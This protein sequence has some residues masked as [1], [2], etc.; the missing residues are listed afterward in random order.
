VP[1][2]CVQPLR[3]RQFALSKGLLAK[4]DRLDARLLAD[5]GQSIQP[6]LTPPTSALQKQIGELFTFSR[7]LIEQRTAVVN[8]LEHFHSAQARCLVQKVLRASRP[9]SNGSLKALIA[10]DAPTAQRIQRLC[11]IKGVGFQTALSLSCLLAE[12]GSI[13][14]QQLAALVGVAPFVRDSAPRCAKRSIRG[15]RAKLRSQLD[16]A[17]WL[18]CLPVALTPSFAVSTRA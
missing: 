6:R 11:S 7:L 4:N 14:T 10:Q 5:F 17:V 18:L 9:R 3:V 13:S 1:I 2:C 16:R 8:E 15:G 12:I